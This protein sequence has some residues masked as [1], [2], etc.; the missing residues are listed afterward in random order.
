M[1]FLLKRMH[2][3]ATI[4][5]EREQ[6]L[7]L[8]IKFA[9]SGTYPYHLS[10]TRRREGQVVFFTAKSEGGYYEAGTEAHP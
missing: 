4:P 9:I 10:L 8:A 6:L 7:Q 3:N 2:K 1:W 5:E